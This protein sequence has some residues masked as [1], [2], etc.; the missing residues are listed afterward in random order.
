MHA[1]NATSAVDRILDFFTGDMQAQIRAQLAEMLLMVFAQRLV[2]RADG[3]GR[4]I[5]WE[6]MSQSLR[7]K[8]AIREG[9]THMLRAMAQGNQDDLIPM[10]KSLA[11]L[12]ASGAVHRDEALRFAGSPDYLD[13]LIRVRRER[14]KA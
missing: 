9:R 1:L 11:D 10:E 2:K 5:A 12:V 14:H 4:V 8:N 3:N 7:V 6:T 13:D